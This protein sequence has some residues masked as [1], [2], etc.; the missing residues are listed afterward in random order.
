MVRVASLLMGVVALAS[1]SRAH[2]Q[3]GPEELIDKKIAVW[4]FDALGIDNEIL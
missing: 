4:R 1:V 3:T 2:A